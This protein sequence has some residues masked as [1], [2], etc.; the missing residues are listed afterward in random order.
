MNLTSIDDMI[1]DEQKAEQ[2][3][4]EETLVEPDIE[5][6]QGAPE[7]EPQ[8]EQQP[9]SE[10]ERQAE[11][12]KFA[13]ALKHGADKI[14]KMAHVSE[15]DM[16]DC[17]MFTAASLKAIEGF[18]PDISFDDTWMEKWVALAV[19]VF[20][21]GS[22]F[23]AKQNEYWHNKKARMRDVSPD[24]ETDLETEP[25]TEQEPELELEPELVPE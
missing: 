22:I 5:N 13:A 17:I 15:V 11:I 2:T 18:F 9:M 4:L 21:G 7:S 12:M 10:S 24:Q 8:P 16:T 20:L 19:C 6:K 1:E 23:H 14:C 25:E 3:A